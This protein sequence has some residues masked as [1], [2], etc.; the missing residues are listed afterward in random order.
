M[1]KGKDGVHTIRC[2]C[3]KQ[4]FEIF[5]T[6][7]IAHVDGDRYVLEPELYPIAQ[8]WPAHGAKVRQP[9]TRYGDGAALLRNPEV[10]TIGRHPDFT[11]RQVEA[12]KELDGRDKNCL[13]RGQGADREFKDTDAHR[14]NQIVKGEE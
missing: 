1:T 10:N 13:C 2:S 4:N 11:H 3:C 8:E 14:L 12:S 7:V 6:A 9:K 5:V